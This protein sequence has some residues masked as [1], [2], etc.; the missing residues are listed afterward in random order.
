VTVREKPI[1]VIGFS[2][3]GNLSYNKVAMMNKFWLMMVSVTLLS[4]LVWVHG[5]ALENYWYWL[6]RQLD[7]PIHFLG[8]LMLGFSGLLFY[9]IIEKRATAADMS[10]IT[11]LQITIFTALSVGLLWELFEFSG[12]RIFDHPAFKTIADLQRGFLDTAKDLLM[13][14]LGGMTAGLIYI[15]ILKKWKIKK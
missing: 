8:G 6:Y 9:F 12:H 11:I 5:L 3:F 1:L 14:V 7:V 2:Y 4:L 15:L 10:A 13:D